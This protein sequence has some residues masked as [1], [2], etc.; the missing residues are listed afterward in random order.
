MNIDDVIDEKGITREGWLMSER[1]F[2][3]WWYEENDYQYRRYEHRWRRE[4]WLMALRM[5]REGYRIVRK[6]MT[7][8][9]LID[10]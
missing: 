9:M 10:E 1:M 2:N 6:S 5:T 3:D 8:R 4:W 7:R